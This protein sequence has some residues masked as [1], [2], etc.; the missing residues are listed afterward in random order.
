MEKITKEEFIKEV[1]SLLDKTECTNCEI[2]GILDMIKFDI[3]A[4]L[5]EDPEHDKQLNHGQLI[6]SGKCPY[7]LG[8]LTLLK[9]ADGSKYLLCGNK[10]C[11]AEQVF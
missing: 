10:T 2:I 5:R 8:P 11:E 9:N 1:Q 6:T 7:C 3:T 4:E